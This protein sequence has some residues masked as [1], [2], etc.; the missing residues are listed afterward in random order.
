MNQNNLLGP[1]LLR[2]GFFAL[3]FYFTIQMTA[4]SGWS[5]FAVILAMFATR[6]LVGTIQMAQVYRHL[7]KYND[8]KNK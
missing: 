6:E 2:F 7:K 4:Y 8:K 1:I 5:F 3:N